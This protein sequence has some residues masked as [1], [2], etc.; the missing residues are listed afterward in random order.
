MITHP[1][2][3]NTAVPIP[4]VDGRAE[5]FV[6]TID[7]EPVFALVAVC[8]FQTATESVSLIL[9]PLGASTSFFDFFCAFVV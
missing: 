5:S 2:I 7:A 4:P 9:Y 1:P 6:S 8:V 3:V